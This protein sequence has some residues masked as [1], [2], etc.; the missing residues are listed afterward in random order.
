M[1]FFISYH[2]KLTIKANDK[3]IS[4]QN[5]LTKTI[6]Q[7]NSHNKL[8]KTRTRDKLGRLATD[9]FQPYLLF[10]AELTSIAVAV[11]VLLLTA[12]S[13]DDV[14]IVYSELAAM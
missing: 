1:Q 13:D 4:H 5:H 14:G 6:T 8:Y 10:T 7:R 12:F 2:D 9:I 11:D 3:F